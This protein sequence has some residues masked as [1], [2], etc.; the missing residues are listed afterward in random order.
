MAAKNKPRAFEP[1]N[2]VLIV[3]VGL[4]VL[5]V[6]LTMGLSFTALSEP[7]AEPTATARATLSPAVQTLQAE[8]YQ[9]VEATGSRGG[10]QGAHQG[11][12]GPAE[13]TA[14]S[15]PETTPDS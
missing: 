12:P 8:D 1:K 4:C 11:S 13:P 7:T 15:G 3:Y 14:T 2:I 6:V 10:G 9:P 5:M